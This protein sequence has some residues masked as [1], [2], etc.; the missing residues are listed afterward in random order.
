MT[1][2]KQGTI[3]V[4]RL[5]KVRTSEIHIEELKSRPIMHRSQPLHGLYFTASFVPRLV[6]RMTF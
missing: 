4:N 3:D 2:F 1:V 6:H 5:C